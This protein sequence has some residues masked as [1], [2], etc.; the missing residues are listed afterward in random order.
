MRRRLLTG[1]GLN[2]DNQN[3]AYSDTVRTGNDSLE[4]E[5]ISENDDVEVEEKLH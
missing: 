5:A 2:K 1:K 3:E 4:R